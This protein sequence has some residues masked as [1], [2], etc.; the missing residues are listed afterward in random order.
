[1][2]VYHWPQEFWVCLSLVS[3]T[4]APPISRQDTDRAANLTVVKLGNFGWQPLPKTHEWVGTNSRLVSVDHQGRVLVG[5]TTRESLGLATREHPGLSFHILRFTSE[6]R[7]DLSLVLPTDNWFNNGLY[8][9]S[10][11]RIYAEQTTPFSSSRNATTLAIQTES[12]KPW[13]PVRWPARSC[14]HPVAGR[15]SLETLKGPTIVLTLCW[16]RPQAVRPM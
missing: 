9:G 10:E 2:T 15:S 3:L 1:M 5:F 6:G 12:G 8:L 11:D 7:E 14:N 13:C 4:L 16:T